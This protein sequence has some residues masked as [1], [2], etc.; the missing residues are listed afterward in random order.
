MSESGEHIVA[1]TGELHLEICLQDLE[2]DHAGVPLKISPPVVA[3][4][5]KLLKVNLLKLLCPSLQT[6]ITE[7]T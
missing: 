7:S 3:Y 6:S 4:R 2:H 1:G 5:E